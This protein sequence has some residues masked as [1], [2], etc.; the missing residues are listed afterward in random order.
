MLQNIWPSSRQSSELLQ[1]AYVHRG[2]VSDL[3]ST[4]FKR[5]LIIDQM[6][7]LMTSLGIRSHCFPK[8]AFILKFLFFSSSFLKNKIKNPISSLIITKL[9]IL[10]TEREENFRANVADVA[11]SRWMETSVSGSQT[12]HRRNFLHLADAVHSTLFETS[13]IRAC[14]KWMV[15]TT[16]MWRTACTLM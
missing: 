14:G 6:I 2:S 9:V 1:L 7:L 5:M 15:N 4:V 12:R 11:L 16:C 8:D 10:S 13:M 3:F